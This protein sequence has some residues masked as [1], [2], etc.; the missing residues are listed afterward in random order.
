MTLCSSC[1]FFFFKLN[2]ARVS[3]A[4]HCGYRRFAYFERNLL[5]EKIRFSKRVVGQ[6][7]RDIGRYLYSNVFRYINTGRRRPANRIQQQR[8][9]LNNYRVNIYY[10]CFYFNRRTCSRDFHSDRS[11]RVQ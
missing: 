5:F 9:Y 7:T 3:I 2:R 10:R 4:G 6:R 8:K 1:G 11:N